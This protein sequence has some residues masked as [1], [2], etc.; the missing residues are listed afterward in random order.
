MNN[1]DYLTMRGGGL[2]GDFILTICGSMIS[3]MK[4]DFVKRDYVIFYSLKLENTNDHA[5]C[6]KALYLINNRLSTK[7][8][9]IQ[10]SPSPRT[11]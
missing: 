7:F 4:E 11:K 1:T 3:L 10:Y 2:Y 5:H 9:V 8:S 6:G